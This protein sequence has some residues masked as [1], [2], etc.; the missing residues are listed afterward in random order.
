[1]ETDHQHCICAFYFHF[2]HR[3]IRTCY[4]I[5]RT[6]HKRN[7]YKKSIGSCSIKDHRACFKRVYHTYINCICCCSACWILCNKQMASGLCVPHQYWLV[8]VCV[9][10]CVGDC[11]GITH[12]KLPG[13]KSS[14]R[15]SGEKFENGV[16]QFEKFEN[17]CDNVE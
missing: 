6:T 16:N 14:N 13:N 1:M 12:N 8:D 7:R 15:K 3:F 11:S 17:E 5:Y 4:F 2:M 9:V 10:R